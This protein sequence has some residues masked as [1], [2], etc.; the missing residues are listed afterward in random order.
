V[1]EVQRVDRLN[2]VG[3][4]PALLQTDPIYQRRTLN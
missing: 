3:L 1:F 2:P 4:A